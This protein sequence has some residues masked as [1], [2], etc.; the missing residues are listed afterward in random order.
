MDAEYDGRTAMQARWE[1]V[2]STSLP[3]Q[4]VIISWLAPD[5][6]RI[7]LF[8]NHK[9]KDAGRWCFLPTVIQL[10]AEL[11]LETSCLDFKCHY[12]YYSTFC[13]PLP[14][15]QITKNFL[16][17]TAVLLSPVLSWYQGSSSTYPWLSPSHL[18]RVTEEESLSFQAL[19]SREDR[20]S[21]H[22]LFCSLKNSPKFKMVKSQLSQL[23]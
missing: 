15:K 16:G 2:Y 5:H 18:P 10:V 22:L 7:M 19:H 8:Y 14:L 23:S 12:H 6:Q 9:A 17:I 4:L 3:W 20:S 21:G 11:E 13:C 1:Y